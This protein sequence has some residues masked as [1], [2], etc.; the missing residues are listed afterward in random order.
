MSLTWNTYL[1]RYLLVGEA[2][3]PSSGRAIGI[4]YSTSTDLIHWSERRL[5]REVEAPWTFECGD[6]EPVTNPSV[7]DP[8][9]RSRNFETSG[10]RPWL[11]FT[12]FHYAG[13]EQTLDR[14]LVRVPLQLEK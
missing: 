4:Y 1:D 3:G 5:L 9:S 6:S 14:D 7:L 13:C 12:R 11:Y 2:D 8:A 10:Q